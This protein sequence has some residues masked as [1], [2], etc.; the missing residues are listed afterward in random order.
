[1]KGS[2]LDMIYLDNAAT[3]PL[4][5]IVRRQTLSVYDK[6]FANSSSPHPAGNQSNLAVTQARASLAKALGVEKAGVYFNSGATEGINTYFQG[7]AR[8]SPQRNALKNEVIISQIEHPA[9][10][11]TAM[12]LKSIG[13]VVR[14]VK[15][16]SNGKVDLD[17][18]RN[19]MSNKTAYVAIMAVN[20]ETG[21]IQDINAISEV[22]KSINKDAILFVDIVQ[23]FGKIDVR[24]FSSN[25]DVMCFSAH[26]FGGPKGVGGL[27]INPTIRPFPIFYGG[28]QEGSFRPGTINAPSIALMAQ[29]AEDRLHNLSKNNEHVRNLKIKMLS[30]LK[31]KGA[32]FR[33]IVPMEFSS[34]YILSISQPLKSDILLSELAKFEICISKRSAC[35]SSS[36]SKSRILE[37]LGI[38]DHEIDRIVRISFSPENTEEEVET[39][40]HVL[41]N[42]VNG[43]I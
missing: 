17:D 13:F 22:I 3:T 7:S 11:Q 33:Q 35:S 2:R 41:T 12:F 42:T 10:Y 38:Q 20:N 9:V 8:I 27:Y 25:A 34:N 6:L 39:F 5:P 21:I 1:M 32:K 18:L 36:H 30:T 4:S 26:K 23:A 14:E 28:D 37:S 19:L 16:D 40:C 31:E 43:T 24:E 15:G 29:A